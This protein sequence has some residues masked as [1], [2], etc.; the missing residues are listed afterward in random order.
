MMKIING[1]LVNFLFSLFLLSVGSLSG[2]IDIEYLD[3]N[4]SL[5]KTLK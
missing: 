1:L 3:Y 2:D 4:W 5:N